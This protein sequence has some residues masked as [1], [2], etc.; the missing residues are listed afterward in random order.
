MIANQTTLCPPPPT[1]GEV[2]TATTIAKGPSTMRE[3]NIDRRPYALVLVTGW[4]GAP[5]T[6]S[7]EDGKTAVRSGS[8]P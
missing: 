7:P 4:T 3:H 2:T 6:T 8:P 1:D 5:G